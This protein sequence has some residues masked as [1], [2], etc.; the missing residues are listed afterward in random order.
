L[1]IV[2]VCIEVGWE[3]HIHSKFTSWILPNTQTPA[4]L[5]SQKVGLQAGAVMAFALDKAAGKRVGGRIYAAY[6]PYYNSRDLQW[7]FLSGPVSNLQLVLADG[8]PQPAV[9]CSS[10]SNSAQ[11]AIC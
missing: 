5:L 11:I 9:F 8:N 3:K 7:R 2:A 4:I 6:V 1:T 10:V